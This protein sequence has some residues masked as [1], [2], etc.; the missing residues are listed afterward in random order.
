MNTDSNVFLPMIP[1]RVTRVA[2][3]KKAEMNI[4]NITTEMKKNCQKINKANGEAFS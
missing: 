2:F 4:L 1:T 3:V